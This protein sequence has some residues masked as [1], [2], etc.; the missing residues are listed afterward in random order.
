MSIRSNILKRIAETHNGAAEMVLEQ[1]LTMAT[2]TEQQTLVDILITRNTRLGW[3]ALIRNFQCLS[4]TDQTRILQKGRELYG[5]LAEAMGEG[6]GQARENAITIVRTLADCKLLTLLPDALVDTRQSIR[7]IA[8]HTLL[9]AVRRFRFEGSADPAADLPEIQRA[10]DA[11]LRHYRMHRQTSTIV[12]ALVTER[13]IDSPLWAIFADPFAEISRATHVVLRQ[14]ADPALASSVLL[15]LTTPL[16]QAAVAGLAT[17]ERPEVITALTRESYRLLDPHIRAAVP[18]AGAFKFLSERTP[19]GSWETQ[20]PQGWLQLIGGLN[21]PDALRVSLLTR[22]LDNLEAA[23]SPGLKFLALRLLARIQAP[24][25]LAVLVRLTLDPDVRVARIA[26]REA[27]RHP[28]A[29]WRPMVGDML[30]TPHESV[31]RL[32]DT[33]ACNGEFEA[34]W[35]T[36]H[37]LPPA[38]QNQATRAA[39]QTDAQFIAQL[40]ARLSGTAAELTMELKMLSSLKDLSPFREQIIALC[41]HTDPRVVATA[42]RLV[43]RLEDPRL[44]NLLEA[45]AQFSDPRVRAGAVEAMETLHV[46]HTSKYVLAMLSSRHNRERANAIRAISKFNYTMAQDCLLKML[47]DPNPLHRSSA[48]WVV[49]ELDIMTVIRQVGL[50]ARKDPNSKVRARADEILQTLHAVATAREEKS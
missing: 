41:A 34:L 18:G 16:R 37:K 49:G 8:G 17:C 11:A 22:F 24:E 4:D 27:L 32:L 10:V 36:Y 20:N 6:T 39:A 44:T 21:M 30:Q 5:P 26:A 19:A 43:G 46:A 1:A 40:K 29:Q 38:V 3:V 48:L 28:P 23:A 7:Q 15:A 31:R 35:H 45:A 47:S 2:G 9:D 50:M 14:L 42:V 33:I 25:V 13:Q 12:A